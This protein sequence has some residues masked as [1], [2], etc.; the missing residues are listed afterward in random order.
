MKRF[1]RKVTSKLN[2]IRKKKPKAKPVWVSSVGKKRGISVKKR[3]IS[4][5]FKVFF[6]EVLKNK[7]IKIFL[8]VL[9]LCGF[10]IGIRYFIFSSRFNIK[11]IQI[12]GCE[13][14]E[15]EFILT[16]LDRLINKNIFFIRSSSLMEEI[17]GYSPYIYDVK[18]EKHLPGD[19]HINI[20]ERKPV[21]LWINLTGAYLISQDGLVLEIVS[22]FKDLNISSEDIDLLRGYGNL[23]EYIETEDEEEDQDN[24]EDG[25]IEKETEAEQP[26]ELQEEEDLSEEEVLELMEQEREEIIARVNQ[27]WSENVNSIREEYSV[28]V[29]VY[30]YDQN[31]FVSLDSINNDMLEN[32]KVGL[33]VDFLGEKVHRYIWESE[34]R[35]VFYFDMRRRIVFSARRDFSDQV[36][37]LRILIE[38][39]KKD[40]KI[41]SF[42]DLSSDIIVYEFD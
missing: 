2:F 11:N 37:D 35:L 3:K 4:L 39:F 13:N 22:D 19:I 15:K 9:F 6:K 17:R 14:V 32:T 20:E 7:Y 27:Y 1:I 33:D 24:E 28:Y 40:D 30:S 31:N 10:V 5:F 34:Y 38:K 18:V 26:E 36:E 23:K 29:F 41:F 42:I 8:T 12:G 16:R 21:F 25:E